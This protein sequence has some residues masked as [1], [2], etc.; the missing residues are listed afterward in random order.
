MCLRVHRRSGLRRLKEAELSRG[1]EDLDK[2]K[3]DSGLAS[4]YLTSC[5]SLRLRVMEKGRL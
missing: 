2:F 4:S 5:L 1:S 3:L